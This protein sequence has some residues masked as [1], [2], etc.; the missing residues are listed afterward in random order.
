[1]FMRGLE[2]MT[3]ARRQT[4]TNATPGFAVEL[5]P[6]TDLGLAILMVIFENG[7]YEPVGVV[8][9][10]N[11]ADEIAQ[12]HHRHYRP[13]HPGYQIAN[14]E[15]WAQGLGGDYRRVPVAL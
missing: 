4:G 15:L 8:A 1:M 14:Y 10:I 3:T 13:S 7:R 9:S 6:T 2:Q 11:E 5:K 12:H